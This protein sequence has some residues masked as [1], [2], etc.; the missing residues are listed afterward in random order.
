MKIFQPF[1]KHPPNTL[2]PSAFSTKKNGEPR[3]YFPF[4]LILPS[5]NIIH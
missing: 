1:A 5:A 4:P 3:G 2:A